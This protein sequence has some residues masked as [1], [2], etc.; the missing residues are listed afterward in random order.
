MKYLEM[1]GTNSAI[2]SATFILL[3]N[4]SLK[5]PYLPFQMH[6]SSN[7]IQTYF[8]KPSVEITAKVLLFLIPITWSAN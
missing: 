5:S 2:F 8:T 6:A 4:N 1:T 3:T 7:V